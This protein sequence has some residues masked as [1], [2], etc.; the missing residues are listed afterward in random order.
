[1][2]ILYA[3]AIGLLIGLILGGRFDRLAR[4]PIRWPWLA[5]AGLLV[6]I[7]L[8]WRGVGNA[9]GGLAP[10]VYVAS[11]FAV[12]V[13]VLRNVRITGFPLIALGAASNLLAIVANGGYMPA[14][15]EALRQLA[16]AGPAGY[17][18]SVELA[19]PAFA[20]LTD[21]FVLPRWL[22]FANVFSIGDVLIGLGVAVAIAWAMRNPDLGLPRLSGALRRGNSTD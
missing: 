2:F 12:F 9:L 10:L 5:V 1:V 4:L 8:F 19:N 7:V 18:N 11:T 21:I 6:Q 16:E 3:V 22:P 13:F 17:S 14:S 15:P 20:P